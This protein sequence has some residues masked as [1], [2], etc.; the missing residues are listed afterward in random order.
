MVIQNIG[1]NREF[2]SQRNT[3]EEKQNIHWYKK[4]YD[5]LIDSAIS[6]HADKR[7]VKECLD[8]ANG[9]IDLE[10]YQYVMNPLS[11]DEPL[12]KELPG[13]IRDVDFMTPIKEKNIGEYINLPY[14]YNIRV[15]N[16]DV[17]IKRNIAL[18][19]A[20][21]VQLQQLMINMMNQQGM[22]TGVPTDT[23]LDLEKFRKEFIET[24][25]DDRA[26]EAKQRLD[27]LN[28]LTNFEIL[29]IQNF[30]N[31][32]A[33]EEFYT[34]RYIDNGEVRIESIS[35]ME[36]FPIDNGEQ[37]VED[38]VGFVHRFI[39]NKNELIDKYR[40]RLS[41]DDWTYL[42]KIFKDAEDKYYRGAIIPYDVLSGR[43]QNN[44]IDDE[45]DTNKFNVNYKG[46]LTN[47]DNTIIAYRVCWKTE[48]QIKILVYQN[49]IGETV[50]AEVSE[51]YEFNPEAGDIAINTEWINTVI[52][53]Y[54]FGNDDYAAVYLAPEEELVQRRD[55]ANSSMCK[56]PFG[57][58]RGL[59]EG[60]KINPIPKRLVPY[61]ALYRIYT[62]HQERTIAKYKGTIDILPKGLLGGLN[63]AK[64]SWYYAKADNTIWYDETDL[65]FNTI[66]QGIRQLTDGGIERYIIGLAEI[67]KQIRE[68]A[69]DLA[70]MND[71]R[72]GNIGNQQTVTNAQS[73]MVNARLGST[74][75]IHMFNKAL[76]RDHTADL[77]FRKYAWIEGK[78]G[79]FID[80]ETGELVYV[81]FDGDS[82]LETDA[83]V[84]VRNS[85]LDKDKL[86]QLKQ[87]AF[88]AGQ[89]GDFE[90]A[91][92]A[93]LTD[94]VHGLKKYIKDRMN[95]QK[96][97][98]EALNQLEQLQGQM[99]QM[100]ASTDNQAR[101]ES[102]EAR[103]MARLDSQERM[104]DKEMA[105][106]G[107]IK[108][109]EVSQTEDVMNKLKMDIEKQKL[110]LKDRELELKTI[111]ENNKLVMKS[112]DIA[113][114]ERI[115]KMNKNKYDSKS[116]K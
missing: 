38:M 5:Y 22:Q 68:E 94:D 82:F 66:A 19:Q 12:L 56:L 71:E 109:D 89:N 59:L 40:H 73:N 9:I 65:D 57:G 53:G 81:G 49:S 93:I 108:E 52:T 26:I 47:D 99:Q 85:E 61:L 76:E 90:M 77:E 91:T 43:V 6:M 11:A 35:P 79:S 80:K 111:S 78:Q 7:V 31:W 21:E 98:Q 34:Y 15:N 83:G 8:A 46:R 101:L 3:M 113:A 103:E 112:K 4:C 30:Y 27:L 86:Q 37:F 23:D 16:S 45:I 84:F 54:R 102:E 97:H 116:S 25:V 58:K 50:E 67:R 115:A 51:D 114:K 88:S 48:K 110:A 75:M 100:Q 107:L 32:W 28:E 36:G 55:K 14:S 33:T 2:P 24:W 1:N 87:L 106:G 70:N 74:L 63:N 64:K 72:Y 17:L 39:I 42:N 60:I 20:L 96:E 62:L 92:E 13:V 105:M 69:W 29:R 41:D 95:L 104:K 44:P 10:M 18:K